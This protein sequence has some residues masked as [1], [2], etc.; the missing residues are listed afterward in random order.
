MPCTPTI[1]NECFAQWYDAAKT[2]REFSMEYR[3]R[4]AYGKTI[5]AFG[6]AELFAIPV[7]RLSGISA[8]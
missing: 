6:S 5:W 2:G 7:E 8:L 1:A 3:F 4:T